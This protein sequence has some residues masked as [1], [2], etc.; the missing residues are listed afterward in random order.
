MLFVKNFVNFFENIVTCAV[1]RVL[2]HGSFVKVFL[3]FNNQTFFRQQTFGGLTVDPLI[4][5]L[6]SGQQ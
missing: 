4:S 6:F 1:G 2:S 5:H 3:L